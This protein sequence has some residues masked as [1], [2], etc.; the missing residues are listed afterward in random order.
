MS[1]SPGYHIFKPPGNLWL[2]G[3]FSAGLSHTLGF[4]AKTNDLYY[5]CFIRQA[6]QL[7]EI[8]LRHAVINSIPITIVIYYIIPFI[9]MNPPP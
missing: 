8:V 2:C 7:P 1:Q 4:S 3:Y 5:S 6:E 9:S